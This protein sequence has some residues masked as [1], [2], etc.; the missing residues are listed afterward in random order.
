LYIPVEHLLI[1][2]QAK[3]I[4]PGSANPSK[5]KRIL[6]QFNPK[7]NSRPIASLPLW[8]WKQQIVN[9]DLDDIGRMFYGITSTGT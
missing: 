3:K 5:N 2:L 4:N 7:S 6:Y 9:S 1:K 8:C